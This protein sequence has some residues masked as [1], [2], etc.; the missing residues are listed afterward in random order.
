LYL[1]PIH[2]AD[3]HQPNNEHCN[4]LMI[5]Q[6]IVAVTMHHPTVFGDVKGDHNHLL[7]LQEVA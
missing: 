3:V 7:L 5:N 1:I 2:S 6:M 4:T